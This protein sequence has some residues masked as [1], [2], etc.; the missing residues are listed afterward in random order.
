MKSKLKYQGGATK[1]ICMWL[2]FAERKKFSKLVWSGKVNISYS[3]KNP[4]YDIISFSGKRDFEEQVLSILSFLYYA[5][6]PRK[7][8]V[9]SDGSYSAKEKELLLEKF[10][11]LEV[12]EWNHNKKL[13]NNKLL[14]CYLEVCHLSK[15][16][17]V[18]LGHDYG[19]QTLYL[20]SDVVFYTNASA[21]FNSG[22]LQQNFWY[23]ADAKS[24]VFKDPG[25]NNGK[26]VFELNSGLLILNKE[27]NFREVLDYLENLHGKF[28]YFSEQSSFN[29]A[30]KKQEAE[31]LDPNQ[32]IVD[33]ED[34]FDFSMGFDR[35]KMALRHY[36]N[37]VRHKMWQKGWK[38][39][40]QN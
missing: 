6:T 27:F 20:D 12:K 5:G 36:V 16:L 1:R 30:F 7:W 3:N 4:D 31:V 32:F 11:F 38:W 18:V 34:Q 9:Y 25:I 10:S 39:H 2:A 28:G 13:D 33:T 8:T 22:I 17:H 40:F 26:E 15:K 23:I 19:R 29:Y 37:P 14:Q 21:Y 24:G 35:S